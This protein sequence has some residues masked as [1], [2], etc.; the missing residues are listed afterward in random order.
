MILFI[1]G[2]SHELNQTRCGL[3]AWYLIYCF[4][5]DIVDAIQR[6]HEICRIQVVDNFIMLLCWSYNPRFPHRPVWLAS[7][8][9]I[10]YILPMWEL[11]PFRA[12]GKVWV[13]IDQ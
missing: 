3:C 13:G 11:G 9:F 2:I 7:G 12:G 10:V 5:G 6:N 8:L 4:F 1:E